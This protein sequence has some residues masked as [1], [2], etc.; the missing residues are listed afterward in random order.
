[1]NNYGNC[2]DLKGSKGLKGE[3]RGRIPVADA[4]VD[5]YQ[6]AFAQFDSPSLNSYQLPEGLAFFFAMVSQV[7]KR[8][9]HPLTLLPNRHRLI[10]H[11][12]ATSPRTY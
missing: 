7:S 11:R 12:Y 3:N 6:T 1:M 9:L 4:Q 5:G 2:S 10:Q 8:R